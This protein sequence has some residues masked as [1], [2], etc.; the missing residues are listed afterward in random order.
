MNATSVI[1]RLRKNTEVNIDKEIFLC[2]NVVVLPV[3]D[4]NRLMKSGKQPD[5]PIRHHYGYE[6]CG[7]GIRQR[8]RDISLSKADAWW[9]FMNQTAHAGISAQ[10]MMIRTSTITYRQRPM[11]LIYTSRI[12]RLLFNLIR[13]TLSGAEGLWAVKVDKRYG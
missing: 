12:K 5:E 9:P 13:R 1:I 6:C 10:L 11:T 8:I 3:R 2:A 4:I 7:L